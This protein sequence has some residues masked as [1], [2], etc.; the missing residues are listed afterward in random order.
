MSLRRTFAITRRIAQQLRRDHRTVALLFVAPVVI[1]TLLGWVIRDQT[2]SPTRLAVVNEAAIVGGM[3]RTRIE[4][5]A[6]T[7]GMVVD[8]VERD[9]AMA[10][11]AIAAGDLDLVVV[12]PAS[13]PQDMAA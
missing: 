13:F 8:T 11:D 9:R 5:A 4:T 6:A 1:V 7:A 3:V 12:I 2:P 10:R